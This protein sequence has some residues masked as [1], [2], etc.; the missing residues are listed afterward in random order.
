LPGTVQE[1]G[2]YAFYNVSPYFTIHGQP[3]TY[4]ETYARAYGINFVP[5]YT[6]GKNGLVQDADGWYYYVNNVKQ[7]LTGFHLAVDAWRYFLPGG[8]LCP[9]GFY[10]IGY[11]WHYIAEGG[12]MLP[13]GFY[14][15]DGFYRYIVDGSI[16]A[17]PGWYTVDGLKHY[18]KEGAILL[19]PGWFTTPD[20]VNRYFLEGGIPATGTHVVEGVTYQFDELG[21]PIGSG[22]SHAEISWVNAYLTRTPAQGTV[23]QSSFVSVTTNSFAN[24]VWF[25]SGREIHQM[26]RNPANPT[27]WTYE[28]TVMLEPVIV[29]Y[30]GE[31]AS[32][33]AY[34]ARKM[35][36]VI[37][38]EDGNAIFSF[39]L[40]SHNPASVPAGSQLT[41]ALRA[42]P[43]AYVNAVCEGLDFPMSFV[44]KSGNDVINNVQYFSMTAP[45]AP[46]VY[47]VTSYVSTPHTGWRIIELHVV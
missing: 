27:N 20:G 10:Q 31:Q 13:P 9:P 18:I 24:R 42:E 47:Y 21:A 41:F 44:P 4:A 25:T 28:S 29:V 34:S 7:E 12:L 19:P 26:T 23:V 16:V 17:P 32:T 5:S 35:A 43:S 40:V 38:G 33:D 8:L 36:P 22:V 1:I 15:I 3:G 14:L 2:E 45:N 37:Y 11:Y 6:A 39:T 30:A 46:G